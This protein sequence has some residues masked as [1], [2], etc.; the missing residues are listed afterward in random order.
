MAAFDYEGAY[1]WK[2]LIDRAWTWIKCQS[3]EQ[4]LNNKNQGLETEAVFDKDKDE[5][6]IHTPKDSAAKFWPGDLGLSGT[7]SV[8]YA[9]LIVEG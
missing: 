2:L 4:H 7:H 6:V 3:K 9:Q 1:Y 8:V 5:F